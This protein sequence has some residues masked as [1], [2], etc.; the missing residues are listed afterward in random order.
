MSFMYLNEI[1][2]RKIIL[3]K[4]KI[5]DRVDKFYHWRVGWKEIGVDINVWN[6]TKTEKNP[7]FPKHA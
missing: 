2:E 6:Y 1:G 4:F 7:F 5:F 3:F